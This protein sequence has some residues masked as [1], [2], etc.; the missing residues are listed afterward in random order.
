MTPFTLGLAISSDNSTIWVAAG[1]SIRKLTIPSPPQVILVDGLPVPN[2]GSALLLLTVSHGR[3]VDLTSYVRA[4]DGSPLTFILPLNIGGA[5]EINGSILTAYQTTPYLPITV[6]TSSSCTQEQG[7]IILNIV[8]TVP[9][10]V[11]PTESN[12][13]LSHVT[14][15]PLYILNKI[16]PNPCFTVAPNQGT[17]T[18]SSFSPTSLNPYPY[19][20]T[21]PDDLHQYRSLPRIRG[22]DQITK[23]VRG[24]SS[25]EATTRK[26]TAVLRGHVAST[27]PFFR[28]PIPPPP[29]PTR[30]I[31]QPPYQP[32]PPCRVKPL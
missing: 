5:V 19:V 24:Q 14:A 29:C 32:S 9:A 2:G 22:I 12:Y 28:K 25:S 1:N 8:L 18:P 26:Q 31:P 16:P 6:I 30:L 10:F 11:T 17:F 20:T 4:V 3:A 7:S 15:C 27:N 13:T 21:P 23:V